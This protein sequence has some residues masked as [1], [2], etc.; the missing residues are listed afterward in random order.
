MN[1]WREYFLHKM[2]VSPALSV[3]DALGAFVENVTVGWADTMRAAPPDKV[4]I[5]NYSSD[6]DN[7]VPFGPI[8]NALI[9]FLIDTATVN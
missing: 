8:K 4:W 2:Y 3:C 6:E 1:I 5:S 7:Y 9:L